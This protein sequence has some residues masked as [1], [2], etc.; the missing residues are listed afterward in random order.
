MNQVAA[1]TPT[2]WMVL[3]IQL[4]LGAAQ[5]LALDHQHRG[6]SDSIF[7]DMFDKWRKSSGLMPVT[8]S[9]IIEALKSE[10]VNEMVLANHLESMQ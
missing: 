5:L 9:T 7:A 8:W 10:S 2:K 3:G 1:K 4:G 6:N